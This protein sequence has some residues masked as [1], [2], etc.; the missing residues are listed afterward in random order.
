MGCRLPTEAEWEYSCR[1]GTSTPFNTGNSLQ[2]SEANYFGLFPYNYYD[3]TGT[4]RGRPVQTGS[5]APNK[6]GLYDMHGNVSEWCSD[7]YGDYP[8]GRLRNPF[9]PQQGLSKVVRGGSWCSDGMDCRSASRS[10]HQ[11]WFRRYDIGF[12]IVSK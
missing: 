1:A 10:C 3:S 8:A 11:T 7:W 4:F 2:V 6:P 5:Y 9:G 12:R